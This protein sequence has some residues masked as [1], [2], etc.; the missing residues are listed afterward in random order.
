MKRRSL[1]STAI[2]GV[3][4]LPVFPSTAQQTNTLPNGAKYIG[5]MKDGKPE[6]RGT[7]IFPEGTQHLGEFRDERHTHYNLYRG[8]WPRKYV[9][10]FKDGEENGQGTETWPDGVKY[11]GG[12]KDGKQNGEGTQTSDVGGYV[13][14]W[15]DG[16]P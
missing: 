2:I 4:F 5:E 13:G 10:D 6:G 15:K 9:G 7:M 14:W 1:F 12:W 16:K 11:V 3:L 8:W